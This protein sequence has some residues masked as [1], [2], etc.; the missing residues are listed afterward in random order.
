[1]KIVKNIIITAIVIA[2]FGAIAY[3][4]LWSNPA[5]AASSGG[6]TRT[7]VPVNM[8]VAKPENLVETIP[9]TGSIEANE[10]VMLKSE[11]SG[12]ITGI[13]FSEGQDR[14]SVV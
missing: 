10:S 1:M 7:E 8:L 13:Y 11:I 2:F 3:K 5:Q 14:K 12:K 4:A 9:V 6:L